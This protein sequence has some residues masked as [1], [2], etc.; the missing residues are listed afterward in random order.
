[1]QQCPPCTLPGQIQSF[2]TLYQVG[3]IGIIASSTRLERREQDAEQQKYRPRQA[4]GNGRPLDLPNR[5]ALGQARIGLHLPVQRGQHFGG[6]GVLA[7]EQGGE[8][9]AGQFA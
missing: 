4:G 8:T 3:L 7:G 6:G 9:L 2:S 5:Y 1:M